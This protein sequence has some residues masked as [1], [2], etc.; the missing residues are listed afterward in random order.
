MQPGTVAPAINYAGLFNATTTPCL[1]LDLDLT[2][3]D[4]NTAY[5]RATGRTLDDLVGRYIFDAFPSNPADPQAEGE[6]S[7]RASLE[8]VRDTGRPHSI[9][10]QKYDIPSGVPGRFLE[11]YWSA[12]NL[13]VNGPDGEIEL[14][15][16]RVLDVTEFVLRRRHEEGEPEL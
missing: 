9:E 2:I 8:P 4:A 14:I 12:T 5:L 16:H 3:R 13:P 15:L 1:V 10:L 11:R 6:H 7:L